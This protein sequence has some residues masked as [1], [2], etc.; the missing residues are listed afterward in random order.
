MDDKNRACRHFIIG[1]TIKA[2][3]SS[4]F[5]YLS[6]HPEICGSSV[7]ETFFF[8]HEYSGNTERDLERYSRYFTPHRGAKVVVEASPNYL[9]YKENI[10]PRIKALLPDAKLLFV[11]RNP[12]DRL[13]SYYNFAVGKLQLPAELTFE[14]YVDLCEQYSLGSLSSEHA[15]IAEK[16]LRALEIGKYSKYLQNFYDA[17]APERIKLALFDDLKRDPVRFMSDICR[18][19]DLDPE[20]F[21]HF[22]FNKINVTFSA[23]L[24]PLHRIAMLLNRAL[25]S[26][27]RQRPDLK[28]RL[29]RIY[30]RL[31]QDREGYTA[32]ADSTRARLT[33]YY[34]QANRELGPPLAGQELPMW[35]RE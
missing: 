28:M 16:H 32:M 30:K 3:T 2:A 12:V 17:F 31:N 6:A 5:T 4:V 10:A 23:R 33:Q 35:I 21:R 25:E 11:I 19:I 26:A 14:R 22:K 24:K 29:V 20:F 13:Y 18:F 1:G 34:S 8:T 7:K 9:G 15:G 27:L